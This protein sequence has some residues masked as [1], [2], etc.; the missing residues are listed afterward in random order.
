MV[1][2]APSSILSPADLRPLSLFNCPLK[3]V[4]KCV[5]H[6]LGQALSQWEHLPQWAVIPKKHIHD[7]QVQLECKC[8]ELAMLS[9]QTALCLLDLKRAF[10]SASRKWTKRVFR[11][12]G[13]PLD[14]ER[15]VNV[16]LDDSESFIQWEGKLQPA[17]L[18]TSGLLQGSPLAA[19]QFVV[20]LMPWLMFMNSR[21][22]PRSL[23]A[24]YLDDI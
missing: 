10:P 6:S 2:K 24:A 14:L 15:L 18:L 22:S 5:G 11:T 9:N 3:A 20:A 12:M 19:L 7:S 4:L 1:P 21:L 16:L 17:F 13:I 23:L 8:A